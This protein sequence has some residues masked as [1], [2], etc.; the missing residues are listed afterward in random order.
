MAGE[1]KP[2]GRQEPKQKTA[3]PPG[4]ASLDFHA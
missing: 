4:A 3:V 1:P 2:G